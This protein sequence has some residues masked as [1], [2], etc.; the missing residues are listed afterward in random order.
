MI[1]NRKG[2]QT[3]WWLTRLDVNPSIRA[4]KF[5]VVSAQRNYSPLFSSYGLIANGTISVRTIVQTE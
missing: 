4:G 1:T 5:V 3:P 2:K